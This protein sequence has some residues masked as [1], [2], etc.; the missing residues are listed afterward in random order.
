VQ[1]TAVTLTTA[2][3]TASWWVPTRPIL[4]QISALTASP[5][6]RSEKLNTAANSRR[7][8]HLTDGFQ[9]IMIDE[10]Y[11]RN[12]QNGHTFV[13]SVFYIDT[14]KPKRRLEDELL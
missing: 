14:R 10:K 4:P 7:I 9:K 1:T 3:W 13:I 12:T 5:S 8:F 2:H 11:S 6:A